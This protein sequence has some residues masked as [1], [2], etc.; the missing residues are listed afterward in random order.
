MGCLVRY[1]GDRFEPF[2][3]D[4]QRL[5]PWQGRTERPDC[6]VTAIMRPLAGGPL[7]VGGRQSLGRIDGTDYQPVDVEI[8]KYVR[9]IQ[10]DREGRIWVCDAGCGILCLS[11]DPPDD[12]TRRFGLEDGL[13]HDN[14][15]AMHLDHEDHVW[16]ATWGGGAC[17]HDPTGIHIIDTG[18]GPIS[19]LMQDAAGHI[20]AGFGAI[21]GPDATHVTRWDGSTLE[22]VGPQEGLSTI[23]C[24]ALH[25][26]RDGTLWLGD[27]DGLIRRDGQRFHRVGAEHGGPLARVYSLAED[28]AGVLY[29]G[30]GDAR[31]LRL[32]CY[33]RGSLTQLLELPREGLQ[34]ISSICKRADG[35]IWFGLGGLGGQGPGRGVGRYS[36][37]DGLSFYGVAEGLP[38]NCV[39]DLCDDGKGNLWIATIGGLSRFDGTEFHNFSIQEGLPSNF[40]QCLFL[41]SLGHLWIGTESGISRWHDDAFQSVHSEHI[42]SVQQIVQDSHGT[43]WLGTQGG[44]VGYAP[45]HVP[46]R[47]RIL[48]IIADEI[49]PATSSVEVVADNPVTFEYTAL[50]FRTHPRDMLYTCRLHGS[51][52][53]WRRPTHD[54]RAF[55][56]ALIEGVY[57]FEVKAID[58][59]L[60]TSESASIEVR[61]LP[62]PRTAGLAAALNDGS[63]TGEFVGN[64]P[65]L[66]R[67]QA[68]LA[69]VA[70]TRETVLILGETGT[71]KGVAA[72][73]IH[74]RSPRK[75]G[76]FIQ[77]NCGAIPH[78]LVESELFGHER[79]AFT[80]ATNRKLGKVELAAGG[81]LFLDEIGDMPLEAQVKLLRLLEE[82]TFERL[83]AM[84]S[85]RSDVRVVAATNRDL[86]SMI[87]D[88][89]F[90]ED[91]YFRL[92]VFEVVLPTLRDRQSDMPLLAA[93]FATRMAAHLN[94]PIQGLTAA[95]EQALSTYGWPG[96]VREL[97]H[98]VKRA[99][100][101][102]PGEEI[103][104]EDLALEAETHV[105]QGVSEW[106][107]LEQYERQYIEQVLAHTGGVIRG[108]GG[109]AEILGLKPST[110][111]GRLK[112]LGIERA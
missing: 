66:R 98:V 7:W 35:A 61:V 102:C 49:H 46:P 54:R 22:T 68:E 85:L 93:F 21:E 29:I 28:E 72:R 51:E 30:H 64:S 2:A 111:Y 100:I 106:V 40:I 50:S 44:L 104:A 55:Y 5:H 13:P 81:T 77:V 71:G 73:A 76:P 3:S 70:P 96:N 4:G 41:D 12:Q 6:P 34:Y 17:C 79:G 33:A 59:D 32:S 94:K 105:Q 45:Q 110:L 75:A 60:N 42:G 83:G 24:M 92:R 19:C 11:G 82:R 109:A 112:K 95:A 16:F 87:R 36:E 101:V 91:L 9:K 39:E 86:R 57:R 27:W 48:Q 52:G 65:A 80:G 8:R 67:V 108:P 63:S 103:R 47:V 1:D 62:N 15:S 97:E 31:N 26:H 107:G 84:Q 99:V 88:G 78:D 25:Q 53:N 58:R 38:D 56:A 10:C 18:Q 43:L 69:Q 74:G 37:V 89:T 90:R 20:W 14:V 23:D